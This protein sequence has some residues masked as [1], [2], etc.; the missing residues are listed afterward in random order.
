MED[1]VTYPSNPSHPV[2]KF[3]SYTSRFLEFQRKRKTTREVQIKPTREG[4][5]LDR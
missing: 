2:N 1:M 5:L 3:R 4:E